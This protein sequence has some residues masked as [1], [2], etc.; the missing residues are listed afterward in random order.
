MFDPFI[1]LYHDDLDLGWRAWQQDIKSYYVPKSILYHVKS[2][3][4]KWS[5]QKFFWLERN[6]KYCLLTHYS[7][8]TYKKMSPWLAMADI[9]IWFVY[10]TKGFMRAK[11]K[12]EQEIK[13]NKD[14]ITSKYIELESKKTV[15]D[16]ELIRHFSDTI[17]VSENISGGLSSS[18]FNS[19]LG[20]MSRQARKAVLTK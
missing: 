1:F 15:S 14:R 16:K 13:K 17:F 7:K 19:L 2:Y 11:I 4:L 8:E 5:A 6:R 3:N 10:F 12:A 20:F 18:I 9:L